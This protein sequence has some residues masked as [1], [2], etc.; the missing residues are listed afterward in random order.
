M[1]E[2]PALQIAELERRALEHFRQGRLREALADYDGLRRLRPGDAGT[3]HMLGV[4][5]ATLGDA[6]N[7]AGCAR[8]TVRLAPAVAAGYRNLGNYLL[9]LGRAAEAEA[10]FREALSLSG[11]GCRPFQPGRGAGRAG[12]ACGR[13]CQLSAGPG[14]DAR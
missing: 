12:S 5:Y 14:A 13:R 11:G 4:V 10:Q 2:P 8:E 6:E 1:T 9:Q 7:A 3:W